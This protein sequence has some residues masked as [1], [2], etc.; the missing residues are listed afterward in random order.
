MTQSVPA[1]GQTSGPKNEEQRTRNRVL[2]SVLDGGPVSASALAKNMKLTAAAIR[3][4]LDA[5]EESGQIEVRIFNGVKAGRGRPARQYV[6]TAAGHAELGTD[7]DTMAIDTLKYIKE[8]AGAQGVAEFARRRMDKL[9]ASLAVS[10]NAAGRDLA[11]RSRA[12]AQAL[13][14]EDFSA[15]ATPVA[16]GTPM[17]A[18]Q[19]CQGHCPIREVAAEFSEFCEV[20]REAFARLLGVDVRRLST[21]ANGDHVCTT[22]IPTAS[23]NRPILDLPTSRPIEG[24]SR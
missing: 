13:T 21:L 8:I 2:A 18:M 6:V 22:H 17:E 15:S 5:L 1:K 4:H 11:A 20:E 24:G 14:R 9:E 23:L 10:V 7:Y 3:R 19:L 16:A 12:L